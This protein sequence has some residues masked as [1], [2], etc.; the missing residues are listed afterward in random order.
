MNSCFFFNLESCYHPSQADTLL[1][2]SASCVRPGSLV[3]IWQRKQVEAGRA[4]CRPGGGAP[5]LL[6]LFS[7]NLSLSSL[8]TE[9][10]ACRD[11][12]ERHTHT[13]T[14]PFM[15]FMFRAQ[16]AAHRGTSPCI[17]VLP[18][19]YPRLCS[20]ERPCVRLSADQIKSFQWSP[21]G[22]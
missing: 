20:E 21:P 5:L 15:S 16:S 19:L 1:S 14:H 11:N 18:R 2:F 6:H 13:H 8:R 10:Q 12:V 3:L 22:S 17:C 7:F 4:V 9:V